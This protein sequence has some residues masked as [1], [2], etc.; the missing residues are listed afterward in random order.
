M[1]T[2]IHDN[3]QYLIQQ[4]AQ[5]IINNHLSFTISHCVCSLIARNVHIELHDNNLKR[6]TTFIEI[7]DNNLLC[8]A[9]I[10][11]SCKN[12]TVD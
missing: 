12:S 8:I 3:M 5:S 4:F 2:E 1:F 11:A 9:G 6:I 7:H 10:S